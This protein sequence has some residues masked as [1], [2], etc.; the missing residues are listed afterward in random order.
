[1][2]PAADTVASALAST[3]ALLA[4]T[5][6]GGWARRVGRA[7]AIVTTVPVPALNGVWATS[8]DTP[9]DDIEAGLDAVA[10]LRVP[11]CLQARPVCRAAV[12]QI[13]ER[14]GLV[15]EPDVPLMAIVGSVEGPRPDG[16]IVR[17]LQPAEASL[18]CEVAGP[19]FGAPS[20]ML[21][22]LI[23]PAVLELREVRGYVGELD[24]EA[25]VTAMSVALAGGV[26]IFN[27]ATL[28]AY[29]R[30]GYG[31][32]ATA[33]ALNDSVAAGAAWGWLQ[34]TDAGYRVYEAL[35][36]TTVESWPC[37][38]TPP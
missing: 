4:A 22:R 29:R 31:T 10:A 37:W 36:F 27:V 9:P 18:H 19:A 20:D 34:S 12:K 13:A 3:W 15:A 26:G 21:A 35:G 28:P 16:L 32:A 6:R 2:L 33:R 25:V 17:Q 8:R 24:G 23:T 14:R 1:M 11:H 30:R 5:L 7:T 38:V